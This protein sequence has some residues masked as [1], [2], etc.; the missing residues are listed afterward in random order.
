MASR[1]PYCAE[2]IHP[3]AVKCKHCLSWLPGST[4]RA[5]A[6]TFG[7]HGNPKMG[8]APLRRPRHDR[9]V[10]GVC[11]GLGRAIGIDPMWVR[12]TYP[13]LTLM[14]GLVPGL[15]AYI[16]LSLAIP[17]EEDPRAEV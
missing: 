3:E 8:G 4:Q 16:I 14:T 15:I 13:I 11:A 1:C 5:A 9:V 12:L 6:V 10:A 2:E 17:S 7:G